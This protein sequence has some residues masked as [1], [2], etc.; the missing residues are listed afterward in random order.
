VHDPSGAAIAGAKIVL[1]DTSLGISKTATTNESGY[2]RI[3][4]IAASIYSVSI[5][6]NGFKAWQDPTLFFKWG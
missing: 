2:F 4:S 1:T 5:E 6:K 3:D